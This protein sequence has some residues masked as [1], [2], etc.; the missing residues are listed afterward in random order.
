[1]KKVII[2]SKDDAID[3]ICDNYPYAWDLFHNWYFDRVMNE[4]SLPVAIIEEDEDG[5]LDMQE[6]YENFSTYSI[7]DFE[8]DVFIG[9]VLKFIT[10]KSFLYPEIIELYN[11]NY[12]YLCPNYIQNIMQFTIDAFRMIETGDVKQLN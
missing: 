2:K 6:N 9:V 12:S 7:L 5:I 10:E 11:K 3:F 1:M 8:V 4:Q